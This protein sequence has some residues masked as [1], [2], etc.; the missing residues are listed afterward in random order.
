MKVCVIG[1]GYIGLPTACIMCDKGF[2]VVGVDINSSYIDRINRN[3]F[4]SKEKDLV[5]MIKKSLE[6]KKL[7]LKSKPEKADVFVICTPTPLDNQ[8]NPDLSYLIDALYSIVPYLTK[9]NIVIIESTVPPKTTDDIIKPIIESYGFEVG[10]D[11]FLAHCP[12]RVIPG[13]IIYELIYNN[14]I[15][16]GCSKKCGEIVAEFYKFFV[17]GEI[18]ISSSEVAEMVK[19]V[20]NSYRDVNIAFS[21]EITTI[22]N[23]LCIDP[24]QV[25]S[26]SNK[27]PRVNLL[28]PGIGVGGH[29]LPVDPH[30]II[31]KA[32][33]CSKLV[34]VARSINDNVPQHL[35]SKFKKI[36]M[37]TDNPKIG[38][39][40]LTYKSNSD[41]IR[42]S[43]AMEIVNL[44]KK[45]NYTVYI[46]D[47][48]VD[49]FSSPKNKYESSQ[50][51]DL[52]LILVDH[53]E[54]KEENYSRVIKSMKSPIIFDTA[55]I[56][57]KSKISDDVSL[58]NLGNI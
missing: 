41:D 57:D 40:G 39:W 56:I 30:F 22:C 25:I 12:E 11:I 37:C 13:N 43:P 33:N 15:I 36:L 6:D 31:N 2:D 16:G 20:E 14:R 49:D 4:K 47:P 7:T 26:L 45:E 44:L 5:E 51:V 48:L 23:D 19:L 53:D 52:L 27:H 24:Y 34:Q 58:Y 18:T 46:Y 50:D 54:F 32:P 35:V 10:V 42:N 55:N 8:N 28:T 38:V 1:I 3:K 21:N 29:C 9:Q 17:K